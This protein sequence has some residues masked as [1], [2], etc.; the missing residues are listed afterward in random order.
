[1]QSSEHVR[2]DQE[3]LDQDVA[4]MIA[5]FGPVMLWLL[6]LVVRGAWN[7]WKESYAK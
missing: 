7:D 3:R 2:T 5:G 1:M 4:K 6:W